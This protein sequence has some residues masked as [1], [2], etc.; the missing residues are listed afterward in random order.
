MDR[1]EFVDVFDRK[2]HEAHSTAKSHL[3]V[4]QEHQ[5]DRYHKMVYGR[6]YAEVEKVWLMSPHKA[7]SRQFYLPWDGPWE[8]LEQTSK[9][10]Y[11]IAKKGKED[12]W[13]IV[14]FNMLKPLVSEPADE[15]PS[16]PNPYRSMNF[17]DVDEEDF[18]TNR[19][20]KTF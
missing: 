6:N 15:R 20:S 16:R 11:K 7:K 17:D 8:I 13:K 12:K 3:G 1:T 9:V 5:N 4:N 10:N 2:F 19:T 14:H 18:W